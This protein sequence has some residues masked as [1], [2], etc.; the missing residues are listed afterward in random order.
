MSPSAYQI[1]QLADELQPPASGKLSIVLLDDAHTKVVLF[2]FA[3]GS[4]L[5]EHVAPVA[6]I[7]QIVKGD[8]DITV[9]TEPVAVKQGTWIQM[10]PKTPHSIKAESPVVLLLTLLKV[11]S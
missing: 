4:G 10:A 5:A 8:A 2:A 11:P 9:G 7:I 1:R 3:A 6:A